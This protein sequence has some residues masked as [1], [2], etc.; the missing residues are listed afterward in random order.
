MKVEEY[1][2]DVIW[3]THKPHVYTSLQAVI[4]KHVRYTIHPYHKINRLSEWLTQ[5]PRRA[6]Q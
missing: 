6:L 5:R 1:I 3:D 4:D 2:D